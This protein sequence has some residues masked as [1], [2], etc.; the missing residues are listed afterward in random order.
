MFTNDTRTTPDLLPSAPD[1]GE[2]MGRSPEWRQ[3]VSRRVQDYRQREASAPAPSASAPAPRENPPARREPLPGLKATPPWADD[4]RQQL[5]E[6]HH[7]L[8]EEGEAARKESSPGPTFGEIPLARKTAADPAMMAPLGDDVLE[9]LGLVDASGPLKTRSRKV[10]QRVEAEPSRLDRTILVSRFLSG[11]IDFI[12][13][14]G[15]SLVLLEIVSLLTVTFLFTSGMAWL[16]GGIFCLVHLVYSFFFLFIQGRTVGMLVAGLQVVQEGAP[17][18]TPGAAMIRSAVF[19]GSVAVCMVGLI[20][21]LFHP[22]ASCW[23][24]LASGS[25][26]VRV[27]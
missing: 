26:V 19:F 14:F 7:Q 12:V 25:R 5:L 16:L 11:L 4:F 22:M 8:F 2:G 13:V 24:D 6:A 1:D 17:R 27:P 21:A 9:D 15:V 3:E 20:W 18:L 23:H 10:G